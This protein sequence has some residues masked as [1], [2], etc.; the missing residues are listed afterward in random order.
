MDLSKYP[1]EKIFYFVAGIIPGFVALLIFNL[2]T[3]NSFG[4]FFTLGFLGYKTKL[5]LILLTAFVAGNTMTTFLSSFLGAIGGAIKARDAQ[6]PYKPPYAFDVAPWREPTWRAVLRNRLK[7]QTPNDTRPLSQE[8]FELKRKGVDLLPEAQRAAARS[9]LNLEK[10][11]ADV[12]D[13]NWARWYDLYHEL[14]LDTDKRD[15]QWFVQTGLSFNLET[16]GLYVVLSAPFVPSVRHWWCIVPASYW[17]LLLIGQSWSE[18]RRY[19]NKWST[20]SAQVAYLS[21]KQ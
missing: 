12:D 14:V 17:A 7:E 10:F 13:G 20:L 6:K 1:L 21:E 18:P 19:R 11:N 9:N 15:V 3:P 5:S 8:L 2:V 16:A 4:W